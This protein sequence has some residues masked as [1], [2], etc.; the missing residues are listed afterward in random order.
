VVRLV[1]ASLEAP[2]GLLEF[3]SEMD[4]GELGIVEVPDVS[5]GELP[6]EVLLQ[7]MV[8]YSKG[9]SL[10]DGWIPASFFWLLDD[11]GAVVAASSLR[12]T[13]TPLLQVHGGHIGYRVKASE[14]GKGYGTQIL[15]LTL[16]EAKRLGL[17][18]VLLTVD[19]DNE[20]SIRIIERNGGVM[21]DEGIDETTGR[22][23]R[24]Y[25]IELSDG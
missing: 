3:I 2:V 5:T 12:H 1:E 11:A 13:L 9:R 18:R 4:T 17:E 23:H 16:P 14:R 7:R 22:L 21:E 20:R 15:A 25:W 10:P 24:R 6:L 19:S 8:D